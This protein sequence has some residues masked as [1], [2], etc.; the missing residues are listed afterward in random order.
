MFLNAGFMGFQFHRSIISQV[1]PVV[2]TSLFIVIGLFISSCSKKSVIET[3]GPI[4]LTPDVRIYS[5]FG[6]EGK[7]IYNWYTFIYQSRNSP[8]KADVTIQ[9]STTDEAGRLIKNET[10][11]ATI[12]IG[13]PNPAVE[14]SLI[15]TLPDYKAENI[16]ITSVKCDDPSV[17]FIY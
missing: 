9:W 17:E 7:I 13:Q 10:Y 2:R 8:G 1:R 11:R 15:K 14:N 6:Q 4:R 12:K 3:A 5:Y 16:R